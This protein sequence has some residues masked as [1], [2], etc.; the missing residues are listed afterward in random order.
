MPSI[1]PTIRRA[2]SRVSAPTSRC[3]SIPATASIS[4]RSPT[5]PTARSTPTSRNAIL[6]CH[7]L[8][9]DQHVANEQSGDRQARLVVGDGRPGQA[10]R[11]RPLFRHLLQRR[12]RLHGDDRPGL[13]QSGDRPRLRPRPAGDHRPRHGARAGDAARPARHRHALLRRRRL[14]GR[15]AGAAMGG[16][17]SGAR[18]LRAADRHGRRATRRRTSPSTR[19]AARR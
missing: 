3:C 16:D 4:C 6:V 1:R 13:D 11:H 9:G 19:S 15:H 2:W 18:L 17:L 10:D 12:R 7:A 14:D 5:R 8:T